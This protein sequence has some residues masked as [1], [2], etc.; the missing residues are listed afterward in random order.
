MFTLQLLG[1]EDAG[2]QIIGCDLHA[3]QQR[4]AMLDTTG[5]VVKMTPTHES[6]NTLPC[7]VRV[8]LEATGSMHGSVPLQEVLE[9]VQPLTRQINN[10]LL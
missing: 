2:I 1:P 7:P 5:E 4:I 6:N 9:R 8:G 10:L 3:R